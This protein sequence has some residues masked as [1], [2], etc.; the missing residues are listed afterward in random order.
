MSFLDSTMLIEIISENIR[1]TFMLKILSGI[2][3]ILSI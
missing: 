2:I 1:L 3:A